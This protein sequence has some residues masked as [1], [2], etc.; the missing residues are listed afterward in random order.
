MSFHIRLANLPHTVHRAVV[1]LC[2]Q[3]HTAGPSFFFFWRSGGF[4]L[5]AFVNKKTRLCIWSII[6]YI[7]DSDTVCFVD[8]ENVKLSNVSLIQHSELIKITSVCFFAI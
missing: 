2:L 7:T 4:R 6:S 5:T 8:F 3:V 1:F